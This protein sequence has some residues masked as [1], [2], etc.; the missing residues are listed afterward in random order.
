MNLAPET[1]YQAQWVTEMKAGSPDFKRQKFN[2][3]FYFT[4][5]N[6]QD[7]GVLFIHVQPFASIDTCVVDASYKINSAGSRNLELK[8]RPTDKY[9]TPQS[10]GPVE[11][12]FASF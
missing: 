7:Y 3:R 5:N 1:G 11:T 10:K 2:Q 12:T 8:K 6:G 4:A 9:G